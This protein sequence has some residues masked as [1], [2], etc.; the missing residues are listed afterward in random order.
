MTTWIKRETVVPVV[1]GPDQRTRK[2]CSA[3]GATGEL[4]LL[5]VLDGNDIAICLD[6]EQCCD[7]YR[8][9]MSPE[10]YTQYLRGM[11]AV[12]LAR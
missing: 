2:S 5:V 8:L 1:P 3:C 11:S 9:G 4:L 7:R 6:S 10:Q 12:S